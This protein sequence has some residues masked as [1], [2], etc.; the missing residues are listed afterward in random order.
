MKLI[1]GLGNPGRVYRYTRHNVGFLI[2]EEFAKEYK[3]K[4]KTKEY[5][6]LIGEGKIAGEDVMVLMPV[7]YMNLSGKAVSEAVKER[8]VEV[9]DLLVICDDIN[10]KLGTIRIRTRGS[11]GGHKGLA[12]I[13]DDLGTGDFARLKVGI[14]T[15]A[16]KGDITEYV[17]S[18][19]RKKDRKKIKEVVA[20]AEDAVFLW[21]KGG[22]EIAMNKYNVR[23]RTYV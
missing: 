15:E 16:V 5:G 13:I 17:L 21:I 10:L 1:V 8:H 19:F 6:S 2:I 20:V 7:T 11:A 14:A 18:P 9:R 12:S 22:P 4:I 3:V 23:N